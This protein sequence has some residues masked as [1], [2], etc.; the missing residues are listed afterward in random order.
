[1]KMI[2]ILKKKILPLIQEKKCYTNDCSKNWESNK[3]KNAR[4]ECI[5][6][7]TNTFINKEIEAQPETQQNI[8]Y[9]D[10]KDIINLLNI[11]EEIEYYDAIF[12]QTDSYFTSDD[13]STSNLDKGIDDLI[14]KTEKIAIVFTTSKNQKNNNNNISTIDLG[15]CEYLLKTAYNISINDSLYIKIINVFQQ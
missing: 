7:E 11:T 15:N 1:M 4:P 13:Y 5:E 2:L 12:N 3:R 10:L 8:I 6:E 9:N 14:I